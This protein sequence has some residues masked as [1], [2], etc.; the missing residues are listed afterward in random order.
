MSYLN[1]SSFIEAGKKSLE[2]NNY[3]SA[4]SIALMLPSMCSRLEYDGNKEYKKK[5]GDAKDKKCY[6]DWCNKYLS[7]D[8]LLTNIFGE[9]SSKILYDLRCDIVHAGHANSNKEM[10]FSF[11]NNCSNTTFPK[12]KIVNV[13]ILCDR[14]FCRVSAWYNHSDLSKMNY[15]CTFDMTNND[16]VLLYWKLCEEERAKRLM[17]DFKKENENK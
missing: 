14:I 13:K 6:I 10:I 15:T 5:D 4:L 9:N 3:W 2:E 12:Y 11:G 1:I 8:E 7:K 16:D 17:E